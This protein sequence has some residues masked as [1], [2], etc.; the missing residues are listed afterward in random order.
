L[1]ADFNK[2]INGSL[3]SHHMYGRD[4][5]LREECNISIIFGIMA[6]GTIYTL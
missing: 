5:E 1:V 3:V 4:L 2:I 6:H